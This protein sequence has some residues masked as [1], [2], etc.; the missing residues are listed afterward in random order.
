MHSSEIPLIQT[1]LPRFFF[2]V[3]F[4]YIC[5]PCHPASLLILEQGNAWRLSGLVVALWW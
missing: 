5:A 2:Y 1:L 4:L 3:L